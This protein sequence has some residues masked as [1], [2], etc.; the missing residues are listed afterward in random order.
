MSLHRTVGLLLA[1]AG[2]GLLVGLGVAI[3][4][5]HAGDLL[6][7]IG[8]PGA[9]LTSTVGVIFLFLGGAIAVGDRGARR[10][11]SPHRGSAAEG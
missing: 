9:L 5:R 11:R 4:D 8:I 7:T 2:L 1:A 10:K 3:Y 6:V